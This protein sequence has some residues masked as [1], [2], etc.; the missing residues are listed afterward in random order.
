VLY[1]LI[2]YVPAGKRHTAR[3]SKPENLFFPKSNAQKTKK[4]GLKSIY[5]D[6][7]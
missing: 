1:R 6:Y 5:A 7:Q 2:R 3:Q 4:T